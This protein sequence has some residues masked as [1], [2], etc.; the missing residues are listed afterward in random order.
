[1]YFI[2]I[3]LKDENREKEAVNGPF[4]NWWSNQLETIS[5]VRTFA[6]QSF[7]NIWD[8]IARNL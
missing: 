2:Q 6:W 5:I 8:Q 7:K 3:V 1:M 4:E